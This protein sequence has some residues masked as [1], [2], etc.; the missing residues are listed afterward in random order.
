[1][2]VRKILFAVLALMASGSLVL[3]QRPGDCPPPDGRH[4]D[5]PEF[6]QKARAERAEYILSRLG[7][8]DEESQVFL[9][10]N[11][12]VEEA[13]QLCMSQRHNLYKELCEAVEGGDENEIAGALSAYKQALEAM[14]RARKEGDEKIAK[15]LS[16]VQMAKFV[17]ADEEFRR[18]KINKLNGKSGGRPEGRPEGRSDGRGRGNG[19]QG[20]PSGG[21]WR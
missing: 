10:V 19:G 15:I 16:P 17:I 18:S 9:T 20:R 8:S 5:D 11:D 7:L 14:D 1:M 13:K 6:M 2:K 4:K 12:E 3:A 21:P